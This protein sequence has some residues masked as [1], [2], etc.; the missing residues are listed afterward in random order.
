MHFIAP[1]IL[2]LS[3]LPLKKIFTSCS[4]DCMVNILFQPP[5]ISTQVVRRPDLVIGETGNG[6]PKNLVGNKMLAA[7]WIKLCNR[8]SSVNSDK[9]MNEISSEY[10]SNFFDMYFQ[11]HDGKHFTEDRMKILMLNL[12][13]VMCDL[14]AAEVP[15][16]FN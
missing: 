3:C 13:F 16:C 1:T 15:L 7:V 11:D 4:L 6:N 2:V 10:A 8:L 5:F 12:P 14:I 9:S